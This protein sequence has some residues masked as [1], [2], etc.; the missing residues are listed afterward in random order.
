MERKIIQNNEPYLLDL[1]IILVWLLDEIGLTETLDTL[2]L[3]INKIYCSFQYIYHYIIKA[4]MPLQCFGTMHSEC[5]HCAS[6]V[7][8]TMLWWGTSP[9]F[10]L[11]FFSFFSIPFV[12]FFAFYIYYC[13]DTT[14]FTIFSQLLRCQFLIS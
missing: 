10:F 14:N 1:K 3:A 12:F 8:A 6:T 2:M 11:F 7:A 4:R 13:I 5:L 9:F